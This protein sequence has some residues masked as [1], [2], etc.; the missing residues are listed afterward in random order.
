MGSD[1]WN[2]NSITA[3]L[4]YLLLW[5]C[6]SPHIN[7]FLIIPFNPRLKSEEVKDGGEGWT[8]LLNNLEACGARKS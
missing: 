4:S 5:P 6:H 2:K 8:L 1:L 3:D 7:T